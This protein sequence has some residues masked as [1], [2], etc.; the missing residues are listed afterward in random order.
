MTSDSEFDSIRPYC[1]SEVQTAAMRLSQSPEFLGL[2]SQ[3]LKIDKDLVVK[4][5]QQIFTRDLFQENFF[6]PAF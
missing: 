2:F 4:S 6:G 3:L 5:L 1:G